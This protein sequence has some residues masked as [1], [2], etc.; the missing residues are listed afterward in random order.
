MPLPHPHKLRLPHHADT[1]GQVLQYYETRAKQFLHEGFQWEGHVS[2]APGYEGRACQTTFH[3]RG[4]ESYRSYYVL[5]S[6][7]GQGIMTD[8]VQRGSILTTRSCGIE[9]LLR[10]SNAKYRMIGPLLDSVE[11]RLIECWYADRVAERTQLFLMNHIDEGMAV[12]R[13]VGAGDQAL[14]AFCLHPLLQNDADLSANFDRVQ[15]ALTD[16][17]DGAVTIAYAMEY[18]SVANAYLA[19]AS[20][21]PTGIR[22]SPIKAVNDMLRGDKVQN[23]RDFSRTCHAT[24][25]KDR[26]RLAEYFR[27]WCHRLGVSEDRFADLSQAISTPSIISAD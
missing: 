19:R 14:R 20:I 3:L 16:V 9:S 10:R 13:L 22:L 7:R 26:D 23:R 21:P 1:I 8:L 5:Q 15:S 6:A 27:E 25:H 18:R 12:M 2:W 4:E 17:R 11:Y 24:T